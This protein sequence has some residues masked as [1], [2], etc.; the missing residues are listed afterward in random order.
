M[1][2][3]SGYNKQLFAKWFIQRFPL[4]NEIEEAESK[5]ERFLTKDFDV[6]M[7]TLVAYYRDEHGYNIML[8]PKKR[9]GDFCIKLGKG[10]AELIESESLDG[11]YYKTFERIN[12]IINE[13]LL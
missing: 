10:I 13:A 5:V 2:I 7:G 6:T 1:L 4:Q 11:V 12:A 9:E 8:D 3:I